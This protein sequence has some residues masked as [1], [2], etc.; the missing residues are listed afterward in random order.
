MSFT[1]FRTNLP[2][3]QPKRPELPVTFP[4]A[5]CVELA[6]MDSCRSV[7]FYLSPELIYLIEDLDLPLT[8]RE[9]VDK[10]VKFS[11]DPGRDAYNA[12]P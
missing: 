8:F 10:V 12:D 4:F 9:L 6:M 1:R 5:L 3:R 2:Y 7:F 11:L